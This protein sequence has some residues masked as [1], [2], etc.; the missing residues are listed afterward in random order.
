MMES[1]LTPVKPQG[2]GSPEDCKTHEGFT[3]QLQV[4]LFLPACSVFLLRKLHCHYHLYKGTP[5]LGL[6]SVL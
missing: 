3:G 4:S 1:V 2:P 5:T 6:Y